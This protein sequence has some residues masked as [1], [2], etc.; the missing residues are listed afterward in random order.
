MSGTPFLLTKKRKL[1]II[2]TAIVVLLF[3]VGVI[4][5]RQLFE[6]KSYANIT[7][8]NVR[9]DTRYDALIERMGE[10]SEKEIIITASGTEAYT[11][12]YDGVSF[13][14]TGNHIIRLI[15]SGEQYRLGGRSKIGVGST[16]VQVE[17]D[18]KRR[19]RANSIIS[20]CGC[21]RLRSGLNANGSIWFAAN[22]KRVEI[23]FDQNGIVTQMTLS[24]E[25]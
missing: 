24:L 13:F 8:L 10:P 16:R 12:H 21:S 3:I 4:Y 20:D 15:I 23:E 1:W 5:V 14:V 18:L 7:G 22:F 25:G 2:I 19:Q 6:F 17:A 11:L 9:I